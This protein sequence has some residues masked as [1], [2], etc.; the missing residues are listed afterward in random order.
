MRCFAVFIKGMMMYQVAS[1][2]YQVSGIKYQDERA[3]NT[4]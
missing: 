1:I 4:C 2:R 3:R